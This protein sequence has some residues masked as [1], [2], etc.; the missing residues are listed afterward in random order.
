[1]SEAYDKVMQKHLEKKQA[2]AARKEQ[3]EADGVVNKLVIERTPMGLYSVRY[4][5]SGPVP[6]ELKGY[7]T[8]RDRIV[9][10]AQRLGKPLEA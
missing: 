6:D 7:F 9:T 2:A 8:R 5:N 10:I 1:M 3:R 4:S